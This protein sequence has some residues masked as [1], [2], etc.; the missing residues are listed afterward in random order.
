VSTAVDGKVSHSIFFVLTFRDVSGTGE[1]ELSLGPCCVKILCSISHL[2]EQ[3]ST[4]YTIF[5]TQ[6][7]LDSLAIKI[8]V[9]VNGDVDRV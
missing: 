4:A 3:V 2:C 1:S 7:S 8:R 9:A 6:H 5:K